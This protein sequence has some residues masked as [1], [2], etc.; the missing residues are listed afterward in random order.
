[1][2]DIITPD[3]YSK[4]RIVVLGRRFILGDNRH[5]VRWL[6]ATTNSRPA[7]GY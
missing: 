3:Q 6:L 5:W 4:K 7:D 2:G 1:M